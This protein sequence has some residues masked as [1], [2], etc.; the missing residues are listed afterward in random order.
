MKF[1]LSWLKDHLETD[2][3]L[4]EICVKLVE[5]GLE[6]EGVDNPADKLKGFVV[7]QV[8]VHGKHPNA[9]RL[10]LCQVDIGKSELVQVVC[11]AT[12]V[13]QG[14]KVVFAGIGT[15]IPVTGEALKKGKIRDVESFGMMCSAG[16]LLL[17]EDRDG[18]MD[19]V[20]DALP[21]TPIIDVLNLND[22]V[23]DVSITPN[24]ADCFGVRGIARDLAASGIGTLRPLP[25]KPVVGTFD[26]PLQV[27]IE[28]SEACSDFRG[29]Y[30]KGVTNGPSPEWVQRRLEAIGLRPISALVDV[31]NYL[32]YDLCRPLHV[33]DAAKIKGNLT[34]RLSQTGETF[35]ALNGKTY[36]L[37]DQMT[38]IAAQTNILATDILALAGVMG[39]ED[40]SC[41]DTTT[42][43]F[44]ECALFDPIRTAN[45]GRTLNLPSD[46]RTRFER[47]VD[48][49]SQAYGLSAALNL[50]LDWCGGQP[51]HVVSAFHTPG[52]LVPWQAPIIRLTHERLL[53]VG[54]CDI[55]MDEAAQILTK[56]GF[57]VTHTAAQLEAKVPSHRMDVTNSMDL[58]EEILRLYGYDN[59]PEVP[60]P[61]VDVT[62]LPKT[63]ADVSRRILAARGF[64][65]T[66]SWSFLSED[67][68]ALFGDIEPGLKLTNPISQDLAIMRPTALANHIDAVVRNANRGL[69]NVKLFEVGPHYTLK[70][71]QLV[72]SGIRSGKSHA[73]HWLEA[74]R[75]VDVYDAK[76]D[77]QAI[78]TTLGVSDSAYQI[79][80]S[81]PKYYHPG[82]SGSVKQGNK[83]L[84]YFGEIHPKT[85]AAFET[86]IPMVA[87]EIFLDNIHQPKAKKTSLNLSPYQSVTRDF[88]FVVAS[89]V[90]ADA[91]VRTIQKVDRPLISSVQIFDV[92]TGDKIGDN[93]KSIA[94]EVKLEPTKATLTEAEINDLSDRIINAVA[95]ATGASLRQ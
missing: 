42:D 86:D 59:I 26:S 38:V 68:A 52:T 15:V 43:V 28:N 54:G 89:D 45:T 35:N 20:T 25:Y 92:Y 33:F 18:I 58:I 22:S 63:K 61:Q 64:F 88:A 53:R 11:G 74:P 36:E 56:L 67:R 47:G 44:L 70:Q 75:S 23:I 49:E 73:R 37:N 80:A 95:K 66:V 48:P 55:S 57:K 79:E 14:M 4:E 76:A 91:I 39:G 40:S 32:S 2:A 46:A 8:S 16:E 83:T 62:V 93:L 21:G 72:A 84:A 19:L 51:S 78:L 5:L 3:S 82:R 9:D 69:E 41:T 24:R 71:Q 13:R 12:N 50:I 31:T 7:G 85:L 6:V 77:V 81:A 10:S 29:V 30:I 90:K 1:T 87:F 34:V 65:E 17:G 60:L 94:V 27:V